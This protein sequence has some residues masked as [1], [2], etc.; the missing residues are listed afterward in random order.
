MKTLLLLAWAVSAAIAG[1][2]L[3]GLAYEV[4][5]MSDDL[6]AL[7]GDIIKEQE[8]IHVLKAEWTYLAR[9]DRIAELSQQY[10]PEMRRLSADQIGRVDD[11]PFGPVPSTQQV[12]PTAKQ[13]VATAIKVKQ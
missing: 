3:Y 10:L 7:Q 4:E 2:G 6:A 5:Q 12:L 1:A 8:T 11:I 13:P 9:P